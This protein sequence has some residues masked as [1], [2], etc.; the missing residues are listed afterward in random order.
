M[1]RFSGRDL[2]LKL[3]DWRLRQHF[4][5]VETTLRAR[6]VSH[7][8]P[9]LRQS[10]EHA[11]DRLHDYAARGIFPRNYE[12]P[13]YSPCFIDRD[14]REC[15]VAHLV[16]TSGHTDLAAHVAAVANY[17]YVPQMA[18]PELDDWAAQA[19]LTRE[20]LT[21]IQPGYYSTLAGPLLNFAI[22]MW[23]AGFVTFLINAVLV[24]KKRTGM[25]V[26]VIA[27]IVSIVLLLMSFEGF[28]ITVE[29]YVVGRDPD[30]PAVISSDTLRQAGLFAFSTLISLI[31]A[32]LTGG[33]GIY[34]MWEHIRS[35]SNEL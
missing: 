11:L 13:V 23:A 2:L 5:C 22:V 29:A 18:F 8:S 33:L 9:A 14:G 6:D 32:L 30:V 15:A 12:R 1:G 34:R 35:E 21:R 26:P 27:V 7:L 20:E 19:G 4:K 17:T 10:R 24:A 28:L 3:E 25:I 16:M 31:L